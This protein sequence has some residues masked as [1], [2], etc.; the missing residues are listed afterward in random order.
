MTVPESGKMP[1]N[2]AAATWGNLILFL[3][4]NFCLCDIRCSI[5]LYVCLAIAIKDENIHTQE[6]PRLGST[7]YSTI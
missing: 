6:E 7:S 4:L 3:S 5:V 1:E 2:R